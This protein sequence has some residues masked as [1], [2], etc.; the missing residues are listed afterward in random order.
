MESLFLFRSLYR[1]N[2]LRNASDR[3]RS[4]LKME[5]ATP[6]S[7]AWLFAG[8][9][10]GAAIGTLIGGGGGGGNG[11]GFRGG[12]KGAAAIVIAAMDGGGSVRVGDRGSSLSDNCCGVCTDSGDESLDAGALYPERVVGSEGGTTLSG[13][14]GSSGFH[15]PSPAILPRAIRYESRVVYL[16]ILLTYARPYQEWLMNSTGSVMG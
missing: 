1:R 7:P 6:L 15:Q 9:G 11:V 12:V 3:L 2:S 13:F 16:L 5:G 4:P 14:C 8:A 10:G